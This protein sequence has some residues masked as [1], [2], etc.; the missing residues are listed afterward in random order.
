VI[1]TGYDPAAS[2]LRKSQKKRLS[3]QGQ[4]GDPLYHWKDFWG[5]KIDPTD[6]DGHGTSMLSLLMQIAPF[7][8]FCIARIAGSDKDLQGINS[9]K[10]QKRLSEVSSGFFHVLVTIVR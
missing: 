2:F 3:L 10:S 9:S 5:D 7:A 4:P 6:T 8:D 1:D